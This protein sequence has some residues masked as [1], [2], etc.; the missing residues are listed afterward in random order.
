MVMSGFEVGS[1]PLP[2]SLDISMAQMEFSWASAALS[3][4][5]G[6]DNQAERQTGVRRVSAQ[7]ERSPIAA[8]IARTW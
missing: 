1:D 4:R 2:G 5:R 6:A 8:V 3:S 7:T